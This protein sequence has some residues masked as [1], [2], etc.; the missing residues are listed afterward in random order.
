MEKTA[1][2]LEI[3]FKHRIYAK[4]GEKPLSGITIMVDPGH[5]GSETGAIGPLGLDYAE[6][7]MN[8]DN[9]FKLK[10]ELESLGAKVLMTRTTDIDL[11]L[12]DRLA[13]SK[14]AMPDMF[15]NPLQQH[16]GQWTFG[17]FR[18]LYL[19]SGSSRQVHFGRM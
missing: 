7:D 1:D 18:F 10:A 14:N 16:A 15:F 5:G 3:H 4:E 9:S 12:N 13:A 6:K 8:L 2:G 17:I 11:S 19:L